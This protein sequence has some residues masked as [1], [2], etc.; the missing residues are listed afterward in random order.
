MVFGPIEFNLEIKKESS[1]IISKKTIKART[2]KIRKL[3]PFFPN[4][5]DVSGSRK[6]DTR[7]A[8]IQRTDIIKSKTSDEFFDN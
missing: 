6:R 7:I 4:I 5:R 1:I 2:F 3:L 8:P